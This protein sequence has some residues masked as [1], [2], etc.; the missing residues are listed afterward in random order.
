M[1]KNIQ[2]NHEDILDPSN[3]APLTG[4]TP[5]FCSIDAREQQASVTAIMPAV[6]VNHAATAVPTSTT[7]MHDATQQKRQQRRVDYGQAMR[8][9]LKRRRKKIAKSW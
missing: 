7:H 9:N 8:E 2:Q 6:A 3:E 4:P 5:T 1:N